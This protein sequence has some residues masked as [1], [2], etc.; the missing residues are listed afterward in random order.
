MLIIDV[1][2]QSYSFHPKHGIEIPSYKSEEDPDKKDDA[3]VSLV[4]FLI[5]ERRAWWNRGG[6]PVDGCRSA[7]PAPPRPARAD[8]ATTRPPDFSAEVEAVRTQ[9]PGETLAAACNKKLAELQAAGKLRFRT[10]PQGIQTSIAPKG[11]TVWERLRSQ[12]G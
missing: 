1:D 6:A 8:L 2:P 10:G 9:Y 3:L 4:P 12:R 5:C 7:P 11:G